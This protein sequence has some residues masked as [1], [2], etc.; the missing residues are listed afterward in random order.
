MMQHESY[1]AGAMVSRVFLATCIT[2]QTT[3]QLATTSDPGTLAHISRI[4]D[5]GAQVASGQA[6]QGST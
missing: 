2:Q 1:D 6:G 5:Q 4:S 3:H